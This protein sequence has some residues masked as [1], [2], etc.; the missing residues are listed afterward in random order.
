[1]YPI[2]TIRSRINAY[3]E[4]NHAAAQYTPTRLNT[5]CPALIFAANRNDSVIGRTKILVVSINTRNGLSQSGAP[6]GRKWATDALGDFVK[7]DNIILSQIGS[8][9][10]IVKI[11]CLDV[12]NIYGI[13]PNKLIMIISKN[14]GA[15]IALIPLSLNINV[16]FNWFMITVLIEANIIKFRDVFIQKND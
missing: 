4:E 8:P 15:I 3:D 10:L 5:I 2:V 6:S 9:S 14:N 11:R 12:L 7:V 16:R 13:S 1:M